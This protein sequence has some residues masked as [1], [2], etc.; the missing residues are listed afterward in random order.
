[1]AKKEIT[2][3]ER[4]YVGIRTVLYYELRDANGE[5]TTDWG[6]AQNA[7]PALSN[8]E[9]IALVQAWR[10]AAARSK[11]PTW[12]GWNDLLNVALG[13]NAPGD[14]FVMTKAHAKAPA[15]PGVVA[16]LWQSTA[17]LATNLDAAGT[18]YK[19]LIVD[20]SYSGYEQAA[21]DAWHQMQHDAGAS[22][23]LIGPPP[24]PIPPDPKLPDAPIP[25]PPERRKPKSSSGVGWLL[26][27]ALLL[28]GTRDRRQNK[29]R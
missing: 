10:R 29:R 8:G 14:R 23:G 20:W 9:V 6:G 4:T 12:K 24:S 21:R 26:A 17:D 2:S 5:I 27:I 18:V 15:D 7:Y 22:G 11:T 16:L 1:V 19:P 3:P 13:W 28:L 25:T